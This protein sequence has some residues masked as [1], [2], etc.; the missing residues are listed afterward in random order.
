MTILTPST[1][2]GGEWGE[3]TFFVLEVPDCES[4]MFFI[5]KNIYIKLQDIKSVIG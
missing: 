3:V 4:A 2:E 5:Y 1:T